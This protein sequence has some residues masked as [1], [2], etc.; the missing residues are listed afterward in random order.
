M[1]TLTQMAES[2]RQAANRAN[3]ARYQQAITAMQSARKRMT[4]LF[5]TARAQMAGQGRQAGI[6]IDVGAGRTLAQQRQR[7]I[8]SGLA[9]TTVQSAV[10]RGVE[11]DRTAAQAR[12]R[13]SVSAQQ[14]GL[15]TQQATAE[16]GGAQAMTGLILK[17]L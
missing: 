11:T 8:S 14:A 3:E 2:E 9:G 4:S 7:L 15:L 10:A 5:A 16:M 12:L 17:N 6:D 1:P 13:E